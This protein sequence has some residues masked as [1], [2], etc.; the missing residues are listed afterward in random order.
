MHQRRA[1]VASDI[2]ERGPLAALVKTTGG[3]TGYTTR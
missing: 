3:F 2:I 1:C